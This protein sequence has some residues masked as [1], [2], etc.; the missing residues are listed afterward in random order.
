MLSEVPQ[1][2][3]SLEWGYGANH[4]FDGRCGL[5]ANAGVPFYVC[6]GTSA[7]NSLSGMLVN[8]K[9]NLL[10]AALQ[11][12][13]HGAAGY[14]ITEWGDGGHWQQFPIA[15]PPIA[16][17][18]AVSWAVEANRDSDLPSALSLHAFHDEAG[19]MGR[20][21]CELGS[22][23]QTARSYESNGLGFSFMLT[24]PNASAA[25]G[26]CVE[27][28][29]ACFHRAL[30]TLARLRNEMADVRMDQSEADLLRA[31]FEFTLAIVTH[32]CQMGLAR[33]ESLAPTT[34]AVPVARRHQLA[35][36]LEP[37]IAEYR[38]LWLARSRPGGLID[39]VARFES[40]MNLYR[41]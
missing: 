40:L 19:R 7:W 22:L 14:L 1:G 33:A 3:I 23:N 36:E 39:S 20:I 28:S 4:D 38:R 31:E 8:A 10:N 21:A 37:L 17:G 25:D 24:N 13:R 9:A 32:A 12:K 30:E 41:S 26:R 18:A 29:P 6:P 5:L 2:V 15:L 34:S 35:M 27:G 11:G 16:Y